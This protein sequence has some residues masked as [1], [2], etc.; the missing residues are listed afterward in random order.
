[1]NI[2]ELKSVYSCMNRLFK[3]K[4]FDSLLPSLIISKYGFKLGWPYAFATVKG[5]SQMDEIHP[6]I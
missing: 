6:C 4:P 3:I 5:N 2:Y 1:M